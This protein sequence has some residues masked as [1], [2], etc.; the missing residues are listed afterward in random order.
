MTN[1]KNSPRV[2]WRLLAGLT[3]GTIYGYALF[4][5]GFASLAAGLNTFFLILASSPFG[6]GAWLWPLVGALL[7]LS[8]FRWAAGA[9][10]GITGLH[11]LTVLATFLLEPRILRQ[12]VDLLEVFTWEAPLA[13]LFYLGGQ[14][15]AWL[16]FLRAKRS[17]TRSLEG[18]ARPASAAGRTQE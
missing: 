15:T 17:W 2:W 6:I 8:R 3:L 12:F 18:I 16:V 14:A 10:A 4:L 13:F 7:G 1:S 5:V 11:E 9:A